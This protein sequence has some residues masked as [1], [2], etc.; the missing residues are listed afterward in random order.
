MGH[1]EFQGNTMFFCSIRRYYKSVT[2]DLERKTFIDSKPNNIHSCHKFLLYKLDHQ[3]E[4]FQKKLSYKS[5]WSLGLSIVG[6]LMAQYQTRDK[7]IGIALGA[8]G[9]FTGLRL[10]KDFCR[11][12]REIYTSITEYE[13][14]RKQNEGYEDYQPP[15]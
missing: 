13:N 3:I 12:R 5:S 8:V 15:H 9:I 4:M 7:L 14:F 6:V 10:I 11:A 2:T 1:K